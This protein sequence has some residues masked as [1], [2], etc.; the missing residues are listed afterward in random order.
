[1]VWMDKP[2][3]PTARAFRSCFNVSP[4]SDTLTR[5]SSSFQCA[6]LCLRTRSLRSARLI[7]LPMS[8]PPG[9][10]LDQRHGPTGDPLG[11][12]LPRHPFKPMIED[13]FL[14]EPCECL[15]RHQG[16]NREPP[17]LPVAPLGPCLRRQHDSRLT[18]AFPTYGLS[19][20]GS[21][22]HILPRIARTLK[23]RL[24]EPASLLTI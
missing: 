5:E 10:R 6:S 24:L 9:V 1:M 3:S 15:R 23:N 7:V 4:T 17:R 22:C 21:R 11:D 19:R 8:E 13:R 12:V 18:A 16:G 2:D 14:R 20:P